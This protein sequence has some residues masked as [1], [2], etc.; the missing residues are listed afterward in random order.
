MPLW[1]D[2]SPGHSPTF[3]PKNPVVTESKE[4]RINSFT[5]AFSESLNK[6]M[7]SEQ[8]IKSESPVKQP[9]PV[10]EKVVEKKEPPKLNLDTKRS[11]ALPEVKPKLGE[12]KR[13]SSV[14]SNER[15]SGGVS[16]EGTREGKRISGGVSEGKKT[17]AEG[18]RTPSEK[19][20]P[21]VTSETKRSSASEHSAH[22][23][24]SI[25]SPK[26][27][28][29]SPSY[30]SK[31]PN[32]KREV[33]K[34]REE[35][36]KCD[37]GDGEMPA[38]IKISRAEIHSKV[39]SWPTERPHAS[40]RDSAAGSKT[41]ATEQKKGKKEDASGSSLLEFAFQSALFGNS[42]FGETQTASPGGKVAKEPATPTTPATP[43]GASD[44]L[45]ALSL[46]YGNKKPAAVTE[47]PPTETRKRARSPSPEL[48]EVYQHK[49]KSPPPPPP[50]PPKP[51]RKISSSTPGNAP[52]TSPH[53]AA[54]CY[55]PFRS[56]SH[57]PTSPYPFLSPTMSSSTHS[58]QLTSPMHGSPVI[59]S[60]LLAGYHSPSHRSPSILPGMMPMPVPAM[61]P[62]PG[63][64][65]P[66]MPPPGMPPRPPTMPL[67]TMPTMPPPGMPTMPP[68][69][70]PGMLQHPGQLKNRNYNRY[71]Y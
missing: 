8:A 36:E 33:E 11:P 32:I 66:G 64:P 16:T 21:S 15:L 3:I 13:A 54:V 2:V 62:P 23:P 61:M 43:S 38:V 70:C 65:P 18:M 10:K 4:S 30:K 27:Q 57:A 56:P 45:A 34:R 35:R 46:S 9:E 67:S 59:G 58:Q 55:P 40:R 29:V 6:A 20:T 22:T 7:L 52:P 12:V 60:P 19:R 48:V 37:Q 25:A 51:G 47:A 42:L 41:P 31:S 24:T 71:N 68:P 63:M 1:E 14:T 53:Q 49:T 39:M 17:P 69:G 28:L 44:L 26:T 5:K 50:P